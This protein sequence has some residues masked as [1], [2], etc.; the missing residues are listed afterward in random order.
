[1]GLHQAL[2]RLAIEGMGDDKHG[3]RIPA[4]GAAEE[5]AQGAEFRPFDGGASSGEGA[6]CEKQSHEQVPNSAEQPRF[7]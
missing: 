7:E 5:E 4:D 1:M 2:L 3:Q 6:A